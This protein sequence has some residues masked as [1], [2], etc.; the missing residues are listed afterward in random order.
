ML[1]ITRPSVE[2]RRNALA[3]AGV[4][5]LA[6]PLLYTRRVARL[7]ADDFAFAAGAHR[8]ILV[9]RAAVAAALH[10]VSLHSCVAI[11]AAT[12]AALSDSGIVPDVVGL[13]DSEALLELPVLK[14]VAG[15]R[16]ALWCAPGG[17]ALLQHTLEQ[18]GAQVRAIYA[19]RRVAQAPSAQTLAKLAQHGGPFA[20]TA[21][22]VALLNRWDEVSRG[23]PHWRRQTVLA[24]SQRI[25]ASARNLGFET[26]VNVAS[27][28][29]AALAGAWRKLGYGSA[30]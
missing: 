10:F 15:E 14:G 21:T 2:I 4:P 6:L 23:H 5:H 24:A 17:R 11:G 19:Y 3:L 8:H 22:S 27:A 9:S 18:R 13:E 20:V 28:S 26:V 1:V 30:A 12:A 16:I 7:A 29:M 25:A